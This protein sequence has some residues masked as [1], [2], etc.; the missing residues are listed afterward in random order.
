M[1]APPSISKIDQI[2]AVN[3]GNGYVG[4]QHIGERQRLLAALGLSVV[5][6]AKLSTNDL[7]RNNGE[8][9]KVL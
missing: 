8:R 6:G 3:V 2:V 9:R 4:D 1:P 5:T 7:Y